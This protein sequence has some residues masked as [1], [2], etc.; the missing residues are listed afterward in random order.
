LQQT[1]S[2]RKLNITIYQPFAN[3]LVLIFYK[4]SGT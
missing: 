4:L 3:R 1:S 2:R